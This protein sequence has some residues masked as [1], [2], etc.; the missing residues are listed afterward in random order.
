MAVLRKDF[1]GFTRLPCL[2]GSIQD[3]AFGE[4]RRQAE[5]KTTMR[6]GMVV[7][8]DRFFASSKTCSSC[9]HVTPKMPLSVRE[10][11]CPEC[12][13]IHNRDENAARNLEQIVVGPAWSEPLSG[14]PIVTHGEIAALAVATSVAAVKLRSVNRELNRC[15]PLRTN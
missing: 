3:A 14:D 10:W 7:V 9:G 2:A 5:Y 12:G 4:I 15:A 8:A 1:I 13:S 6:G 11:T